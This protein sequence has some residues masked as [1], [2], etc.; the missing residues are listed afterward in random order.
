MGFVGSL[1]DQLVRRRRLLD[2]LGRRVSL[3]VERSF[4]RDM[5]RTF[6]ASKIVFND[7]VKDDLNMRVFEALASG[8]MLLTDRAPGSGLEEM[9]RDR[10][11][12]VIYDE[13]NL[14]DLA[15]YYLA[16]ERERERIAARGRAEALRWHTYDHRAASLIETV[17]DPTGAATLE[18][19][20]DEIDDPVL[21]EAIALA[22]ARQ[23]QAALDALTQDHQPARAE[24]V[25]AVPAASGGRRLP[26]TDRSRR[27]GG[28][29][30]LRGHARPTGRRAG[31]GHHAAHPVVTG[32]RGWCAPRHDLPTT[33]S[34]PTIRLG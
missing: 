15:E 4:F 9:F 14:E 25:G 16:H 22:N 31:R 24:R 10:E 26:A 27:G 17:S 6:S 19:F 30:G 33:P 2:R 3:H 7:A 5:A 32:H 23:P 8:S 28:G 13:D 34:R 20:E 18:P 11:H 1:T 12:L 21:L 29:R